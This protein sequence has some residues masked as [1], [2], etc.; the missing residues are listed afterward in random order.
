MG[1]SL[2][3]L[4]LITLQVST[5]CPNLDKEVVLQGL[6]DTAIQDLCCGHNAVVE[7]EATLMPKSEVT[8]YAIVTN[9]VQYTKPSKAV[10]D[11]LSNGDVKR[12]RES[13]NGTGTSRKRSKGHRNKSRS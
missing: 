4:Y 13:V 3:K 11:S 1:Q 2:T 7:R 5:D 12:R 10:A 9:I 6:R 8:V